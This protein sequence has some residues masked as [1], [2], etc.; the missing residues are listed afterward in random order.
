MYNSEKVVVLQKVRR[1][2]VHILFSSGKKDTE[3]IAN[4]NAAKDAVDQ[5]LNDLIK[6]GGH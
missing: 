3:A 2:L 4:L 6:K 1:G 5:V